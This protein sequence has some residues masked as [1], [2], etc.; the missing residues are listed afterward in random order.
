[1]AFAGR[2]VQISIGPYATESVTIDLEVA[3][4]WS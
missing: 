4:G 3:G 1:V 2:T